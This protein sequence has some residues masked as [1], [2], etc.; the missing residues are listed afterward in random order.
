MFKPSRASAWADQH[1]VLPREGDARGSSHEQRRRK[2][3]SSLSTYRVF[4]SLCGVRMREGFPGAGGVR[5][6][7]GSPRY[8]RAFKMQLPHGSTHPAMGAFIE[9]LR[10]SM[11][12]PVVFVSGFVELG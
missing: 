8:H 6:L 2:V 11:S 9:A 3:P 12:F 5:S 10:V 4:V 1:V 7:R